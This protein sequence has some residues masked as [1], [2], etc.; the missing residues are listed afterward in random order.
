MSENNLGL[1]L[2]NLLDH[3]VDDL[4]KIGAQ[5]YLFIIVVRLFGLFDLK[6]SGF[7]CPNSLQVP[8]LVSH[9]LL[10]EQEAWE[11]LGQRASSPRR[12][13]HVGSFYKKMRVIRVVLNLVEYVAQTVLLELKLTNILAARAQLCKSFPQRLHADKA[14]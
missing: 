13:C 14:H 8:C 12:E 2:I 1:N 9:L 3:T 4:D 10:R 6:A 11:W 5:L 7:G